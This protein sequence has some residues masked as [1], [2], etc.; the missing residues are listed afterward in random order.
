MGR[1]K[2]KFDDIQGNEIGS[3]I[4]EM[5][6][7]NGLSLKKVAMN[8][9]ALDKNNDYVEGTVEYNKKVRLV[10]S[11]VSR[12]ER[13]ERRGRFAYEKWPLL[14]E[15]CEGDNNKLAQL[16]NEHDMAA[17]LP[18]KGNYILLESGLVKQVLE[19]MMAELML[20]SLD[21]NAAVERLCRQYVEDL[22]KSRLG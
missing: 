11:E 7:T 6:K 16:F 4:R 20:S 18:D 15:A 19:K 17:D 8:M 5:R 14:V 1:H 3:E 2:I 10:I 22:M 12:F 21:Q 9:L 13:G